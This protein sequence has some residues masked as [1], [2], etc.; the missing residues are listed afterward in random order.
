MEVEKIVCWN[1]SA[2]IVQY[3]DHGYHGKRGRCP[4]CKVDFPLE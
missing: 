1:C 3:Y 4:V 2:V